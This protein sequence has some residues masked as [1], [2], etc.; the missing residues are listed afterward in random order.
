MLSGLD[1]VM[2]RR[3]WSVNHVTVWGI[4]GLNVVEFLSVESVN[5]AD[6]IL[7]NSVTVDE[8]AQEVRFADLFDRRGNALPLKIKKPEVIVQP[9]DEFG[10]FTVG[11]VGSES[12]KIARDPN[13]PGPVVVD[14]LIVEMGE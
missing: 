11:A 3:A 13:A 7:Y 5:G 1:R 10:A 8:D 2:S 4:A 9:K 14:L 12:F 6:T